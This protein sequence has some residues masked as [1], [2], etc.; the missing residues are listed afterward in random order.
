MIKRRS[1]LGVPR[2]EQCRRCTPSAL[3]LSR[4]VEADPPVRQHPHPGGLENSQSAALA[5]HRGRRFLR[6]R[7][8]RG[9]RRCAHRHWGSRPMAPAPPCAAKARFVSFLHERMGLESWPSRQDLRRA[10]SLAHISAGENART[11]ARQGA[12]LWNWRERAGPEPIR[13]RGRA[14]GALQ[15]SHSNSPA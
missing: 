9:H 3:S 15:R 11:L 14:G 10:Q 13:L 7:G 6:P 8:W 4:A 5:R 1:L 12:S 2:Y